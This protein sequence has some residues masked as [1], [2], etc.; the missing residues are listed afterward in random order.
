MNTSQRRLRGPVAGFVV[1]LLSVGAFADEPTGHLL[2]M[3]APES[4]GLSSARLTRITDY[5]NAEVAAGRKAGAVVLIAR[6]GRIAYFRAFGEADIAS[7]RP[8][9]TDAYFRLQSMTKPVTSVALLSL[10]EQGKFGL[11]DPLAKYIPAFRDMKVLKGYDPNGKPEYESAVR[12]ITIRDVFRHTAGFTYGYFGD[13]PVDRAYR[14][15][16]VGYQHGLTL[17]AFAEKLATMPLLYQPGTHWNYGFSH[18][19]QAYLVELFS[20]MSFDAYCQKVIFGPLGMKD[21]VWG[22]PEDRRGRF[23]SIYHPTEDGHIL[24]GERAGEWSY[25]GFN[26]HPYGGASLSATP[27]DY[28]RFA[29]MLLNGGRLGHTRILSRKTVELMTHDALGPEIAPLSPGVGY[30][31]GVGV[32]T[33]PA[34]EGRLDSPGMFFWGG[35]ATTMVDIDPKE[36][37]ITLAFAQLQPS[38]DSFRA[39]L[40]TLA[41]QAIDD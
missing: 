23:A 17:K 36:Q 25:A 18:D 34:A 29:A 1:A 21:T 3:A 37:M 27:E 16:G 7:H 39:Q 32:V 13:S 26:G 28:L 22:V 15:G 20:G 5:V 4:V 2:P 10:Y 8:M 14:E 35:Y 12:P 6:R 30:G 40:H 33:D 19:I 9:P 38:D 41:Y 31:L 24:P 11:D